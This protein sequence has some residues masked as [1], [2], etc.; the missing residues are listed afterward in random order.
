[1]LMFPVKKMKCILYI[2]LG[3]EGIKEKFRTEVVELMEL[4]FFLRADHLSFEML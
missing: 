3:R 4:I 2:M 1:M